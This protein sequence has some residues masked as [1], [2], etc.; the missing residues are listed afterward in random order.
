MSIEP[1]FQEL[2]SIWF[3]RARSAW[4]AILVTAT[5]G[6]MGSLPAT[7]APIIFDASPDQATGL[8]QCCWSNSQFGQ[9]FG[10]RILFGGGATIG[11][12]DIY[13]GSGFGGVGQL[14]VIRLWADNVGT[15]GALIAQFNNV[16]TAKDTNGTSTQPSLARLHVDFTSPLNL[17]AGVAYWIGMSPFSS[18]WTQAGISGLPGGSGTMAQFIAANYIFTGAHLGDM[19]FRLYGAE[20]SVPAPGALVLFSLGLLG[21]GA[22]RRRL[23]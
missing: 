1:N 13:T 10:D 2:A 19:A 3:A 16:V 4:T 17:A 5:I 18:S 9:N 11:G 12:M 22:V 15:P 7:A 8:V 23:N 21:L 20:A 6:L 14:A